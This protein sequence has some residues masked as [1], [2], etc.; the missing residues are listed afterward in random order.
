MSEKS[1]DTGGPAE[2][3]PEAG[4]QVEVGAGVESK[5]GRYSVEVQMED[6][7]ETEPVTEC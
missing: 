2:D 4:S 7:S 5:D 3:G 1:S 6:G